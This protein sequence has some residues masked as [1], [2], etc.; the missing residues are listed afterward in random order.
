MVN[1][2]DVNLITTSFLSLQTLQIWLILISAWPDR[3]RKHRP[4]KVHITWFA[5]SRA[6]SV[7]VFRRLGFLQ[8]AQ[9]YILWC[10]PSIVL[11][12]EG[13][14][15]GSY[16]DGWQALQR[17]QLRILLQ[18]FGKMKANTSDWLSVRSSCNEMFQWDVRDLPN[19]KTCLMPDSFKNQIVRRVQRQSEKVYEIDM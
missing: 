4:Q 16:Y 19:A 1:T 10:H 5:S 15:S 2:F 9:I 3:L 12:E 13:C 18:S 14:A 6:V 11:I 7:T 8:Q 17:T